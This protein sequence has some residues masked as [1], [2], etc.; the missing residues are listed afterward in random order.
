MAVGDIYNLVIDQQLHNTAIA[1]VFHFEQ[2]VD[3]DGEDELNLMR[4]FEEQLFPDWRNFC[5]DQWSVACMRARRVSGSGVFPEELYLPTGAVGNLAEEAL[6]ANCVLCCTWYSETFNKSGRGRTYFS[7][8]GMPQESENTWTRGLIVLFN[9]FGD[10]FVAPITDT[11]TGA[12]F[13]SVLWTGVTPSSKNIG[14]YIANS[15]VRKL[16]GRTSKQCTAT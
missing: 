5:S 12:V 16:R 13:T 6:P 1:N 2:T 15:D 7:G 8:I 14:Q 11:M 10:K 9:M 3:G 4:G